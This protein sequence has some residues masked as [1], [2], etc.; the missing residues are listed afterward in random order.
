M[1]DTT[2]PA[3]AGGQG[4]HEGEGATR[5][6][7]LYLATAAVGAVGVASVAWPFINSMN[8]AAD[9]L[10]L[11]QIDVDLTPVQVGQAIT[12]T[13]RGKPVFIRRRTEE[14][15][16]AA[17]AV[18]LAELP[19]PAPD[20][21]RVQQPQWLV[22]VGVCTHLGCVPLGQKPT[23][24]KGD[25]GGWFCPCHGSHYDTSG[26]IRRGPAPLNLAVPE[27]AFLTDTS[28]RLG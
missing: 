14:E 16:A 5:R 7:F 6:D 17:Q 8:P 9:T 26:R 27:Y 19:D 11:A 10:A 20:S 25:Y 3:G 24:P 23:D 28:I 1:S 4:G 21:A 18:N 13:W 15:I 2:H 22:M 12:V